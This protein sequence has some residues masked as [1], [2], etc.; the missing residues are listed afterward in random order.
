MKTFITDTG[1]GRASGMNTCQDGRAASR[2]GGQ[3]AD[4]FKGSDSFLG[5]E[6]AEHYPWQECIIFLNAFKS[7]DSTSDIYGR[8]QRRGSE[9]RE[10]ELCPAK[11]SKHC[12]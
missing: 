12:M 11:K 9:A 3:L 1:R 4:G 8:F 2:H 6:S 5:R 10:Y 7:S